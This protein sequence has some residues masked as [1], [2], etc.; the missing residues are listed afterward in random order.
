MM[1]NCTLQSVFRGG[2]KGKKLEK[3]LQFFVK[4]AVTSTQDHLVVFVLIKIEKVKK[5]VLLKMLVIFGQLKKVKHT[6][7]DIMF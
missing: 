2:K 5:F 6:K 1:T 3:K 4:F 7:V